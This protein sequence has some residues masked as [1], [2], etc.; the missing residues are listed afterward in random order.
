[1]ALFR[2]IKSYNATVSYW[3]F[4]YFYFFQQNIFEIK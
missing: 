4:T 2:E 3:V 1:M